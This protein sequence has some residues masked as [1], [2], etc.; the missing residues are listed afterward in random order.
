MVG[1]PVI[2]PQSPLTLLMGACLEGVSASAGPDG[3]P[4]GAG[5]LD[6]LPGERR[7]LSAMATWPATAD[8]LSRLQQALGEM[9]SERWQPPRTLRR[10]GACFVCFEPVQGAG[11]AGDRG[12]A[13]AVVTEGRR[14]LARVSVSGPAG[15]PYLP[16]LLALQEGPL[17]E[18]A[19]RALPIAP[20]VLVVNATGRD[21]PRRAGLALHLGAVLGL[22]TVGVTT[23]PLLAQGAWPA[24]QRPAT[25]PLLLDNEVVGYWVRTRAGAKPVAVHAAWRTDASDAVQVV[26][27]A[28][29]R[30]RDPRAP[31]PRPHPGPNPA[32]AQPL[33]S[34]SACS[35]RCSLAPCNGAAGW[36]PK[37]GNLDDH[38]QELGGV[39]L[40]GPQAGV[41][42][43]DAGLQGRERSPRR[44]SNLRP[45]TALTALTRGRT[46]SRSLRL[47]RFSPAAVQGC[48][49][50][51]ARAR[52]RAERPTRRRPGCGGRTS[53]R[54]R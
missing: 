24:D 11:A 53:G 4:A 18:Q 51:P 47:A 34:S 15:G 32:G 27:A 12:F 20:E 46:G 2:D 54:R 13:G 41:T 7:T 31:A 25:A 5:S 29:R 1:T 16:A 40:R 33:N 10:I 8:E 43:L 30:A 39:T 14:L 9:T 3:C 17:L 49:S 23:R 21:H 26:L 28:T 36:K 50:L 37:V 48:W 52:S 19:V 44:V 45:S 35:S 6:A 22:P 42:C 38:I